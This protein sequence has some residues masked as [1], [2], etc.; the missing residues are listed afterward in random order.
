MSQQT[1]ESLRSILFQAIQDL[2][3]DK[4][5]VDKANSICKLTTEIVRT[6]ELEIKY[7]THLADLDQGGTGIAAGPLLLTKESKT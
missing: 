4:I 2:N 1:T 5:T 3:D 7:S 6:A